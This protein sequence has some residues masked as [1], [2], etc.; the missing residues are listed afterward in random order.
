MEAPIAAKPINMCELGVNLLFSLVCTIVSPTPSRI[1][2]WYP[3]AIDASV[4]S[5]FL[6]TKLFSLTNSA[7]IVSASP[8]K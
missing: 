2:T 6:N 8:I 7:V 4:N 5:K 1:I 3:A